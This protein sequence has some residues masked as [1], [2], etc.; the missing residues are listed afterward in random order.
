MPVPKKYSDK[1]CGQL[2]FRMLLLFDMFKDKSHIVGMDNVNVSLRFCRE[3]YM[4]KNQVLIHGGVARKKNRGLPDCVVQEE[5]KNEKKAALV[6]GTTKAAVVENDSEC[7]NV[8][9]FSVYDTK[10]VHVLTTCVRKLHWVEKQR[11]VFDPQEGQSI[12]MKYL[13]QM[14]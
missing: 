11:K 13:A 2:H 3:A 1:G 9:A 8:V 5:E 14:L 12:M 7:P 4:G 6:R 10:P